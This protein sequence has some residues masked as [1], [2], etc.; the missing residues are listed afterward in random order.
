[1][2]PC[3]PPGDDLMNIRVLEA[4]SVLMWAG[5]LYYARNE[6]GEGETTAQSGGVR[7]EDPVK[8][9]RE[10]GGCGEIKGGGGAS[11]ATYGK[12]SGRRL[13]FRG[14]ARVSEDRGFR[15]GSPRWT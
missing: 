5:I 1:M 8:R 14:A 6:G 3:E 2:E 10:P 15:T 9:M 12:R 13:D 7:R 4:R 11:G